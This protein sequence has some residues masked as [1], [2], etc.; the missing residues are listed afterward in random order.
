MLLDTKS[1]DVDVAKPPRLVG[2]ETT[3]FNPLG[4]S[5]EGSLKRGPYPPRKMDG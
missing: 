5:Q 4:K 2:S 3:D 1:L